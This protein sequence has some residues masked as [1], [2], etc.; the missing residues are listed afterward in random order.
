MHMYMY[1]VL[2]PCTLWLLQLTHDHPVM[3]EWFKLCEA[4][5]VFRDSMIGV[6][7]LSGRFYS[8]AD[9]LLGISLYSIDK[10]V[11]MYKYETSVLCIVHFWK[12]Q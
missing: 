3:I 9:D 2:R 7:C 10:Y 1:T 12:L 8:V 11:C 4:V 6:L 5:R